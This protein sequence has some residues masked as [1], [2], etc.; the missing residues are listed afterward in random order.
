MNNNDIDYYKKEL[1]IK[2]V[3]VNDLENELKALQKK[4]EEEKDLT[5]KLNEIIDEYKDLEERRAVK[6]NNIKNKLGPFY[7]ILLRI[8]K[9]MDK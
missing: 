2:Q 5:R 6:F 9:L 1:E 3:Q 4:L 8:K 7:N